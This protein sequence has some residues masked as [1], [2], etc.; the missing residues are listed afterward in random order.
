[1]V[2]RA[3]QG[4]LLKSKGKMMKTQKHTMISTIVL[5]L[6]FSL[7]SV[8]AFANETD[9]KLE[10]K[11]LGNWYLIHGSSNNHPKLD[12]AS[13]LIDNQINKP[14]KAIAPGFSDVRTFSDQRAHCQIYKANHLGFF[15]VCLI[16]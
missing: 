10:V 15:H 1:M 16:I 11:G 13:E 5:T 14:F 7:L 4:L 12:E 3:S 9:G 8:G 6:L 2:S